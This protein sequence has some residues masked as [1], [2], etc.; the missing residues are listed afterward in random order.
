MTDIAPDTERLL[1]NLEDVSSLLQVPITTLRYWRQRGEGP[2]SFRVGKYVRYRAADVTAWVD[3][4][5]RAA[6]RGP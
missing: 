5:A 3:E 4:Q 6:R 2:P 1:L